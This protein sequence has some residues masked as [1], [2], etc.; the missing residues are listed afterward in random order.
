MRILFLTPQVP[1]PPRQ[2]TQL[3]NLHMLK[4]AATSHQVDLLSFARPG[5]SEGSA[6]P[7]RQLCGRLEL[8]PVPTRT[9]GARLGTLLL[10]REP[11]MARRLKSGAFSARLE[12]LLAE[13][14]Y[15]AVHVAGIEMARYTPIAR[16]VSPR[17][18]VV[19]DDHNAEY[20]LQASAAAVDARQPFAW[21]KAAYSL[22]QWRRLRRYERWTCDQ[23]NRVIAVS[24][25]D[26]RALSELGIRGSASVVPNSIDVESYRSK[27]SQRPDRT[28]LIFTGTMDFRPNVDAATWFVSEVLPAIAEARP[29]TRLMIVG[30]SP[31]PEVRGLPRRNPRV[32]VTGEVDDIRPLLH[33]SGVFVVPLRIGGGVRLKVMEAMAAGL[34]VVSTTLGAAGTGTTDGQELLVADRPSD[35]AGAVLRLFE[36]EALRGRLTEAGR[37]YAERHFDWRQMAPLLLAVYEELPRLV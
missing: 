4:A 29:A 21:H 30:R 19:F 36:D 37:K 17:T 2:G 33:A 34:P 31:A 15:D 8:V 32:V 22:V 20:L 28:M 3:R 18:A 10:S 16:A 27:P 14:R 26:S 25:E 23:S 12:R 35:F 1:F 6:G 7:L 24:E 9:P 5:E 11:D 13:Q